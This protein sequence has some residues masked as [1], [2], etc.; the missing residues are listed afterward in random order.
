MSGNYRTDVPQ[1]KDVHMR[2]LYY[3][4][5]IRA[6]ELLQIERDPHSMSFW[7]GYRQGQGKYYRREKYGVCFYLSLRTRIFLSSWSNTQ[8]LKCAGII[9]G[10]KGQDAARATVSYHQYRAILWP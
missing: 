3:K 2:Y 8:I 10:L 9:A 6:S 1:E 5:C 4:N 7:K